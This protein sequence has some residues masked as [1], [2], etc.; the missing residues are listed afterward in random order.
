M[1]I[2]TVKQ[3]DAQDWDELVRTTYN[4]I[5]DY[6]QQD[7]CK[8]RGVEYINTDE[9]FLEDYENDTI[10]EVINGNDMGV[11]FKAWLN[12]DPESPLNPTDEE[13]KDSFYYYGKTDEEKEQWK[14]NKSRIN[15]FWSRNFYPHVSMIANDL[16]KRGL[17]E[18]G[19]YQINIDW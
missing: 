16:C 10:P 6:Q 4:K 12:R 18:P 9:N 11:S 3:I 5:Y 15:L 19:E 17:L 8:N 1:K 7:G 14:K 13:L 2:R